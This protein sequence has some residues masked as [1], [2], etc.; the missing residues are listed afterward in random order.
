[1]KCMLLLL[2]QH[3]SRCA[4]YTKNSIHVLTHL[5]HW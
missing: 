2:D 1:L 5:S 3:A 4:V